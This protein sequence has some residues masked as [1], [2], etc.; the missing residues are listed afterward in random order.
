MSP[1]DP[2]VVVVFREQTCNS[3]VM[4]ETALLHALVIYSTSFINAMN[5]RMSTSVS[6]VALKV[7]I[8]ESQNH[9]IISKIDSLM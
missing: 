9:P 6:Q 4:V 7:F 3:E 1:T 5:L 8:D 2:P